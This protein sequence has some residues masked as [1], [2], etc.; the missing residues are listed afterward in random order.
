MLHLGAAARAAAAGLAGRDDVA[1]VHAA[2][3]DGRVQRRFQV[4]V[5][6][7]GVRA[8]QAGGTGGGRHLGLPQHFVSE[9]VPY[10]GDLGLVEQP[11][12]DRDIA[13]ADQGAEVRCAHLGGVRPERAD[14]GVQPDPAEPALVEEHQRAA[15]GELEGEPVPLGLARPRVAAGRAASL[16]AVPR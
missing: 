16:G 3:G 2:L 1:G 10:P 14:I 13:L 12:L 9:Q 6:P 11:G 5:E 7:V 8:P 15:V 4:A